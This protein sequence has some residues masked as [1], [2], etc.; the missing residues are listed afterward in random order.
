MLSQRFE[1]HTVTP[2]GFRSVFN[3]ILDKLRQSLDRGWITRILDSKD[4][5]E[6]QVVRSMSNFGRNCTFQ[7]VGTDKTVN[8]I[9]QINR[10]IAFQFGHCQRELVDR[11][12]IMSGWFCFWW[13]WTWRCWNCC[14]IA[15]RWRWWS[16]SAFRSARW[17]RQRFR[18]DDSTSLRSLAW[19]SLPPE[20]EIGF[21][22]RWRAAPTSASSSLSTLQLNSSSSNS[23]LEL[24]M[25][26][27]KEESS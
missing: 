9:D 26:S 2:Q 11:I 13:E 22:L 12:V 4:P 5:L 27:P 21:R 17:W 20:T 3:G 25:K 7:T 6:M 14:V 15:L 24:T 1:Q 19:W 10:N 16:S 23:S 8:H 18:R